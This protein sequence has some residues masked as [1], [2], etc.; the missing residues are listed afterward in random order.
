MQKHKKGSVCTC[1][2]A[3]VIFLLLVSSLTF[4]RSVTMNLAFNI[5]NTKDNII[6]VNGTNV[7]ATQPDGRT[8]ADLDKKSIS[9]ER[10]NKILALVF[11]GSEFLGTS[12]NTTYSASNYLLS[13]KQGSNNRFL[14]AF[15]NGTFADIEKKA[16]DA[17]EFHMISKL[18][19][20]MLFS[21]QDRFSF[22]LRLEYQGINLIN[23]TRFEGPTKLLIK[24]AGKAGNLNN[25]TISVI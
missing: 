22:F 24:N 7:N 10:R 20:N 5:G 6:Y 18:L 12:F 1:L 19:G 2:T 15:T 25:V 14:I 3:A 23:R 16:K 13:M 17:E 9:S 11:A 21:S 8:F 4:A